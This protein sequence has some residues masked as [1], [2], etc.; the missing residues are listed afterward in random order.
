MPVKDNTIVGS[1][2]S[3]LI[4]FLSFF[5]Q[6]LTLKTGTQKKCSVFS[7]DLQFHIEQLWYLTILYVSRKNVYFIEEATTEISNVFWI[8]MMNLYECTMRFMS[9]SRQSVYFNLMLRFTINW[10]A[11]RIVD[12][13][14]LMYT[15]PWNNHESFQ[16]FTITT[17][18]TWY[19]LYCL[20]MAAKYMR[21]LKQLVPRPNSCLHRVTESSLTHSFSL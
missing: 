20:L 11:W 3:Q 1:R 2:I 14:W 13:Y 5:Q 18:S 21:F 16:P 8:K 15:R 10:F 4:E 6:P 17:L 7:L 12:T 9:F 19:M